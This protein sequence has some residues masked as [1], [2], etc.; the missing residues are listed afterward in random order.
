MSS[1]RVLSA[2]FRAMSRART[3]AGCRGQPCSVGVGEK[4]DQ[5]RQAQKNS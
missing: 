2:P 1:T 5:T 4:N 3:A